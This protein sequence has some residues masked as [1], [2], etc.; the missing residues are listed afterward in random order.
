MYLLQ[1]VENRNPFAVC[2][3]H[4]SFT[5]AITEE[6]MYSSVKIIGELKLPDWG[7]STY[8]K[9]QGIDEEGDFNNL[10]VEIMRVVKY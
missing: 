3:T 7:E 5:T 10:N 6:T 1:L 4:E 9:V 2:E 8:I